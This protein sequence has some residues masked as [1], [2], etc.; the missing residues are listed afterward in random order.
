MSWKATEKSPSTLEPAAL[1]GLI[2]P[3]GGEKKSRGDKRQREKMRSKSLPWLPPG[4][5]ARGQQG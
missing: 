1:Q 3:S 5:P 4:S 2:S